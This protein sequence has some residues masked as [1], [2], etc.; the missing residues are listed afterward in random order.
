LPAVI[1]KVIKTEEFG[2][3]MIFKSMEITL[4]NTS[5]MQPE[6]VVENEEGRNID[7]KIRKRR[8]K[9]VNNVVLKLS[10]YELSELLKCNVKEIVEIVKESVQI[11]EGKGF[12]IELNRERVQQYQ[13]RSDVQHGFYP[14]S[15]EKFIIRFNKYLYEAQIKYVYLVIN[16]F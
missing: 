10:V 6:I 5:E 9:D 4:K 16:R 15:S 14:E 13:H 8:Q 11:E 1:K 3:L 2:G 12:A 7:S